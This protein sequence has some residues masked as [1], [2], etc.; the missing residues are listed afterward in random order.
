MTKFL[1]KV[2][3]LIAGFKLNYLR[4]LHMW[5]TRAAILNKV[6]LRKVIVAKKLIFFLIEHSF[7]KLEL[8]VFEITNFRGQYNHQTDV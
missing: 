3:F 5:S 7:R 2:L 8:L 1:C 4:L 6:A